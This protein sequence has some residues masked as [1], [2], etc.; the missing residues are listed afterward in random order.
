MGPEHAA[1]RPGRQA[2]VDVPGGWGGEDGAVTSCEYY[3]TRP[4]LV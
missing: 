1:E 3:S 2:A 4:F